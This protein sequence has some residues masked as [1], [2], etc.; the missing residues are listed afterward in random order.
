MVDL[1]LYNFIKNALKDGKSKDEIK[2]S[3]A[4]GGWKEADILEAFEDVEHNRQPSIPASPSY[5]PAHVEAPTA[6]VVHARPEFV[7]ILCGYYFVAWSL[8]ALTFLIQFIL[9]PNRPNIFEFFHRINVTTDMLPSVVLILGSFIGILGYWT[10]ERWG[11]FV[12]TLTNVTALIYILLINKEELASS[13]FINNPIVLNTT[14]GY[15]I[16]AIVIVTGFCY[17]FRMK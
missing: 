5:V 13:F 4:K 7:T 9:N 15:I 17:W 10:M 16:P 14:I 6:S 2:T 3:V 12:F 1:G 8:A 11:V